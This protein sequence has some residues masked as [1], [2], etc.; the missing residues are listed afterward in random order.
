MSTIK[1]VTILLIVIAVAFIFKQLIIPYDG[2]SVRSYSEVLPLQVFIFINILSSGLRYIADQ[3]TPPPVKLIDDYLGAFKSQ[4]LY[5]VSKLDLPDHLANGPKT[6]EELTFLTNVAKTDN[7]LRLLRA[8]EGFGY[9]RENV[10]NH[11]WS[12]TVLSSVLRTDHPNSMATV[13]RHWKE[14]SYDS[15][16]SLFRAI[17]E[18]NTI[19]FEDL[20]NGTTLWMH[21]EKN[22][23]RPRPDPAE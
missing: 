17:T 1:S 14:D 8:A 13:I 5:V 6:I 22:R 2:I 15:W 20:H 10:E 19:V 3:L 16:G 9:F 23:L 7:I 11:M 21:Y 18:D 12:N 4:V